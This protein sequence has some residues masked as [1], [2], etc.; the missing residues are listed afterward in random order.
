[1]EAEP[2]G[3][4]RPGPRHP[5]RWLLAGVVAI[6]GLAGAAAG[7]G[8]DGDGG[9]GAVADG[10]SA[11]AS[12]QTVERDDPLGSAGPPAPDWTATPGL[13]VR[14]PTA[15]D[16]HPHDP[17]LFTQGLD[18]VELPD[19]E[20]VVWEGTGLVGESV[21]VRRRGPDAGYEEVAN[22]P[23]GD[24][25][26]FGE[27]L[28][29]VPGPDPGDPLEGGFLVRLT[30]RDGTAYRLDPDTL[31][32]I[33]RLDYDREGWGVCWMPGPPEGVPD[34]GERADG[35]GPWGGVLV[36]SD[37][38]SGIVYRHPETLAPLGEVR[39]V[40]PDGEP[41]RGLN[42]L[43]CGGDLIWANVWGAE[44][45]AAFDPI[46]GTLVELADL[47]SLRPMLPTGGEVLNGITRLGP[48]S[49]RWLATGKRWPTIFELTLE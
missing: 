28:A 45:L 44:W 30:W 1:M 17:V 15:V 22:E 32:E 37:G 35:S 40:T 26:H 9:D 43:D 16:A 19:G 12:G 41:I 36:T 33:E 29:L 38:S 5:W 20:V 2:G 24:G 7:C 49:D 14:A 18:A 46:E 13:P 11:D 4:P 21:T 25:S 8:D 42:E 3:G 23:L 34:P 10:G 48:D 31:A 27:G 6:A 39:A 47:S